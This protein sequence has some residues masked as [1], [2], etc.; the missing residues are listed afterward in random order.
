MGRILLLCFLL[1]GFSVQ[2]QPSLKGGL[3]TFVR[4]NKVYP[5]YSLQNCIQGVVN[6]GFKLNHKGEVFYSTIRSGVGTDLDQEALRL[7]RLSSG[8]W[9]VPKNH[10][11]TVVLIAPMAFELTGYGCELKTKTDIDLA[12]AN[13]KS[14]EGITEVVLNF[15]KNKGKT[16]H[17][18]K[19]EARFSRL[20]EELGYNERYFQERIDDGKRKLKQKDQQGACEDFMFVKNMG[21]SLADEFIAQY[22]R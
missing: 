15:Y 7:I 11:T 21:S 6:I 9:D 1:F 13:Y 22:C 16:A 14:N 10:D 20:K 18:P 3:E 8:K 4:N 5:P 2:S 17:T 12:I 19:D